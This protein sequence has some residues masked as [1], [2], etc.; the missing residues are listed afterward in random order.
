[1][2]KKQDRSLCTQGVKFAFK[3][4]VCLENKLVFPKSHPVRKIPTYPPQD[5]FVRGRSPPS[6]F[7][8]A[9]QLLV[10]T[11]WKSLPRRQQMDLLSRALIPLAKT[12]RGSGEDG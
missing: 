9:R 8:T 4:S 5:S 7:A 6:D 2:P 11:I 10:E 1:M 12:S 3:W